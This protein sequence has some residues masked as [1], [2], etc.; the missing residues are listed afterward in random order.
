LRNPLTFLRRRKEDRD[1]LAA[2]IQMMMPALRNVTTRIAF[3]R[4]VHADDSADMPVSRATLGEARRLIEQ[5]GA[6]QC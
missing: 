3:G 4:P 6:G 2:T 1:W 5:S